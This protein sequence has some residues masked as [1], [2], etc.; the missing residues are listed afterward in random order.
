VI[1]CDAEGNDLRPKN[2][3][4]LNQ[5]N[6]NRDS[7]S[8]CE[9]ESLLRLYSEL[10]LRKY[11]SIN[12]MNDTVRSLDISGDYIRGPVE[13]H[14]HPGDHDADGAAFLECRYIPGGNL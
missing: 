11:H 8:R 9:M 10:N 14:S 12:G 4:I 7:I 5:R 6:N 13:L 3:T 2:R 1:V